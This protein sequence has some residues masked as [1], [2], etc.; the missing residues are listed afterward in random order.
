MVFSAL[1]ALSLFRLGRIREGARP[2]RLLLVDA[3]VHAA[4]VA[5]ILAIG[6]QTSWALWS[7]L[8]AVL[9][10]ATIGYVAARLRPPRRPRE[11]V[12]Q[13]AAGSTVSVTG[14]AETPRTSVC[15][16]P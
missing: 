1:T 4:A 16:K 2:A 9:I 11:A 3:V 12:R 6:L 8:S 10:L 5:C 15:G 13:P 7:S 14:R